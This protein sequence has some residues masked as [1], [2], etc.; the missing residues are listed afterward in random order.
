MISRESNLKRR[1][2]K[3]SDNNLCLTMLE[4][5]RHLKMVALEILLPWMRG[6]SRLTASMP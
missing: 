4:T 6:I 1:S 5:T 3:L 2:K